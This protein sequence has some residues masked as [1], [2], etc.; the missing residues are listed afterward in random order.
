MFGG[1]L[2]IFGL[3]LAATPV[4]AQ[5]PGPYPGGSAA[6]GIYN[7]LFCDDLAAFRPKEGQKLA[8][9]QAALYGPEQDAAKVSKLAYASAVEP[10]VRLLAL[11]WLTGQGLKTTRGVVLGVVVEVPVNGGLDVLAAYADGSVRYINHTQAMTIIEPGTL[12]DANRQAIYL[13]KA[14]KPI[15]DKIGPLNT[16]RRPAPKQPNIRLTFLVSD[17]LYISDGA[18]QAM[19]RDPATGP[20]IQQAT[21]LLTV[22]TKT[23]KPTR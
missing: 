7:P 2:V 19:Q 13:V 22:V 9:W 5:P 15:A 20:F 14:A 23:A 11:N 3:M 10:R 16:P 6:N 4:S 18:F 8:G 1:L 21:Q 17:G 12:E